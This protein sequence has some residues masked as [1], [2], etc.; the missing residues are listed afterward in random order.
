MKKLDQLKNDMGEIIKLNEEEKGKLEE[1]IKELE[2][3]LK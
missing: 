3:A 1:N 2:S